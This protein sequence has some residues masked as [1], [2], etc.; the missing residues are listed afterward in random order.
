MTITFAPKAGQVTPG[1][2]RITAR[3][4]DAKHIFTHIE[5]HMTGYTAECLYPTEDFVW[6]SAEEILSD[7]AIPSAFRAY[8]SH[9]KKERN[10]KS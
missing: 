4:P 7:Y 1:K 5:W 6:K 3:A 9:I 2:G 10:F 8:V